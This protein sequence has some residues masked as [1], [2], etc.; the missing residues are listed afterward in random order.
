MTSLWSAPCNSCV[1]YS[2]STEVRMYV[3]GTFALTDR[4]FVNIL[5]PRGNQYFAMV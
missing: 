4:R 2:Y 3:P 1:E 5:E